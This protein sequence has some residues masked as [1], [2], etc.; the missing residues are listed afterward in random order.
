MRSSYII[1]LILFFSS[2]GLPWA[3]EPKV[4]GLESFLSQA[5]QTATEARLNIDQM[6][7]SFTVLD[8]QM[9]ERT[10]AVTVAD[11][12]R[13]VPGVEI[14]REG[15]G[16][17]HVLIRGNY[18]DR[19][20]LILW[21]GQPLNVLLTRR[22]FQFIGYLPVDVLE[23]VEIS[24]GPSSSVYG[25]Y[26]VGGVIN[27]IPRKWE[28]GG[29]I[30]AAYGSFVTSRGFAGA[31]FSRGDFSF[32]FSV[33]ALNSKGERFIALDAVGKPGPVKLANDNNWQEARLTWKGL[34]ANLFRFDIGGPHYYEISDRLSRSPNP[35]YRIEYLGGHFSYKWDI[36]PYWALETY[37]NWRQDFI[38]Y[39]TLYML[40]PD[41][42]IFAYLP[43]SSYGQPILAY[44]KNHLREIIYGFWS[45]MGCCL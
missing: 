27:L 29:E 5:T 4:S 1:F 6:P 41:D 36:K 15:N 9:I 38:D 30:G 32:Q 44:E 37:L 31:G 18:S 23:R 14:I 25:S 16:S 12:L 24:R 17:Y 8:R 7:T 34:K 2:W 45:F 26:A 19:R 42:P 39:G 40:N 33:G 13:F 22:A 43:G 20:V 21:D 11:L 10:G 3:M 35:K 28:Q